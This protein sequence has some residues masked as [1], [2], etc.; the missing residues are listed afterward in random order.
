MWLLEFRDSRVE[1][2]FA[3]HFP[4]AQLTTDDFQW[5]SVR[6]DAQQQHQ[7][8][9]ALSD[10]REGECSLDSAAQ[11]MVRSL[12]LT[13]RFRGHEVIPGRRPAV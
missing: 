8:C 12:L 6:G 1:A 10:D 2:A 11:F 13:G 4:V 5:R 9:P 3:R 7:I